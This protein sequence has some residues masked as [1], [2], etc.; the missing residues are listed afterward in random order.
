MIYQV[1]DPPI[2]VQEGAGMPTTCILRVSSQASW[3]KESYFFLVSSAKK[4]H[5]LSDAPQSF[6]RSAKVKLNLQAYKSLFYVVAFKKGYLICIVKRG[7]TT[8]TVATRSAGTVVIKL[9]I[10]GG[11]NCPD[12]LCRNFCITPHL[13]LEDAVR[14]VCMNFSPRMSR[15]PE[16]F[17]LTKDQADLW[18]IK[19]GIAAHF[20]G[21]SQAQQD[22][23]PLTQQQSYF[24]QS[25][26]TG[27]I[28]KAQ[29]HYPPVF[30][31]LYALPAHEAGDST[32]TEES[33]SEEE[34]EEESDSGEKSPLSEPLT[35]PLTKKRRL[36]TKQKIW[37]IVSINK[38]VYREVDGVKQ[39]RV[40][41]APTH[42]TDLE[43][44]VKMARKWKD[45]FL[46]L[47]GST[48]LWKP[49]YLP[50]DSLFDL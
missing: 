2:E 41:W 9:P 13:S 24:L 49:G 19:G 37:K 35:E 48:V 7:N 12:Y 33:D 20:F 47:K 5:T 26:V 10:I 23:G 50:E 44:A 30:R 29:E 17:F 27:G 40:E 18:T 25:M 46:E 45:S 4:K 32:A 38:E 6:S 28:Q 42:C 39:F 31:R 16:T 14:Q 43:T 11:A 22:M 1:C 15:P 34:E 3:R 21:R 8:A 36:P